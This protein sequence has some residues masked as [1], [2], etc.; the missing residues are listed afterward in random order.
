V[1][2]ALPRQRVL[3]V[4]T[5]INAFTS[6]DYQA[7]G[8]TLQS[9]KTDLHLSDS[10]LGLLTGMAFALFYSALGIPLARW[11]D[12]GNRVTIISLCT[13]LYG[14][15]V[16]LCGIA[17]NFFTLMLIRIGVAVGE[18]GC[19]P[20]TNSLLADYFARAERPRAVAI[21]LLGAPL[22][23]LIG[24]LLVGWLNQLYG[25]RLTF[26]LLGTP[27]LAL[28]VI[29]SLV[30]YE[31]RASVTLGRAEAPAQPTLKQVAVTLW[32]KLTFR[33][34]VY[35]FTALSFFGGGVAQWHPAFLIRSFGL[36][37][38]A[39]GT[40]LTL[41]YGVGGMVGTYWSGRWA[42]RYA[43]GN[44]R[45][46]LQAIAVASVVT[47]AI[48]ALLY[49]SPDKYWA[50]GCMALS[51]VGFSMITAPLFATLQT[52]VPERM[53]A[54]SIALLYL[55]SNLIG[56][57]FGPLTVGTLS[58]ALR[59]LVGEESLRYAL[60]AMTPGYLWAGWHLWRARNTVVAE[61]A[62]EALAP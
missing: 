52:L 18:A 2:P 8:L 13:A 24:Y 9:I 20:A 56:M 15:A 14:G 46:Q 35:G 30:L 36:N 1:K 37:S 29:T 16:A 62:A 21:S 60:L 58:D 40:W 42:S 49:F 17:G 11:A 57:G 55:F 32:S 33:R 31:P 27:G 48:S 28:A 26:G 12:R 47:G 38:A 59:P 41:I 54:V 45:R 44:E 4:L 23:V 22:S 10:Q 50:F 7:L 6:V 39:S 3:L 61:V 19:F 34:L 53:R 25:W 43:A 5:V 51:A